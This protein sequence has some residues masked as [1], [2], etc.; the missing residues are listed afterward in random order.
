MES[1]LSSSLVLIIIY[2][3]ATSPSFAYI[4]NPAPDSSLHRAV[5]PQL[6][7]LQLQLPNCVHFSCCSPNA[8]DSATA[9]RLR[10]LQLQL[11]D[12]SRFSCCSPISYSC[13]SSIVSTSAA[14]PSSAPAQ[15]TQAHTELEVVDRAQ[16]LRVT[17]PTPRTSH[18][19]Y[20]HTHA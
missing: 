10:L 1:Q 12:C 9:P 8:S 11:P 5:A 13:C 3:S 4:S 15:R 7:P 2:L 17:S 6:R 18:I 14:Q 19:H 20:T 16:R